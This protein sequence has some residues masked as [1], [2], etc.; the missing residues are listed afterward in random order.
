MAKIPTYKELQ[1]KVMELEINL[2]D[3]K[4]LEQQWL[5][6]M[7]SSKEGFALYDSVLNLIQMND[8]AL[9]ML[10]PVYRKKALIGKNMAEFAPFTK[11]NGQYEKFLQ[12]V[13]T[14]IP[15]AVD[16]SV[17]TDF[18]GNARHFRIK[19]FKAGD[20]LGLVAVDI[21][22]NERKERELLKTKAELRAKARDLEELNAALKILLRKREKDKVELEEKTILNIMESVL[23]HVEKLKMGSLN[24]AQKV[25]LDVLEENLT[26]ILS[27]FVQRLTNRNLVLTPTEFQIADLVKRGKNTKKIAEMLNAN[28]KT[29]EFHRVNIRKKFGLNNKKTKL[30]TYLLSMS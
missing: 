4:Q 2:S 3:R 19:A 15:F 20:G 21:T 27:V 28:P 25:H 26:D 18:Q 16:N 30:R 14:G 24:G 8:A 13:K 5:L 1:Q 6:F 17:V 23:P 9:G 11:K 10:P 22:D 29:I 12:V 7:A